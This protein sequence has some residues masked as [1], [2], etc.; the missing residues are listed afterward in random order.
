MKDKYFIFFSTFYVRSSKCICAFK[1]CMLS[2]DKRI[3]GLVWQKSK[4]NPTDSFPAE[5][6]TIVRVYDTKCPFCTTCR[7]T[8]F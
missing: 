6:N 3:L 1:L 8:H 5:A 7:H 4:K 2:T